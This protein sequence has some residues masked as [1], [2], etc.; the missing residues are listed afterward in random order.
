MEAAV[1]S[2]IAP[3]SFQAKMFNAGLVLVFASGYVYCLTSQEETSEL[4]GVPRLARAGM[5]TGLA[6]SAVSMSMPNIANGIGSVL[7]RVLPSRVAPDP[8]LPLY[9][10]DP[11]SDPRTTPQ[12]PYRD[13]RNYPQ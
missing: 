9:G 5:C 2:H 8:S 3:N 4:T 11:S 6:M 1:Q 10:R 13:S 12:N 7:N